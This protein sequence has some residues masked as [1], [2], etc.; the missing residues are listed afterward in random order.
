MADP[1]GFQNNLSIITSVLAI[2]IS[3]LTLGW[4]IYRDA[5][6]KPKLRVD[7]AVKKIIQKGRPVEGPY[8]FIEALNVGPIP[9]RIGL[10]FARKSW[11]KRRFLDPKRGTA[12]V[13]P[14]FGHWATTRA[15]KRLEVGDQANFVF[16]YNDDSFLKEDFMQVGVADGFGKIH[17]SSQRD[18][19]KVREKYRKDFPSK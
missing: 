13:Y 6:R 9:N 18:F 15:S 3:S 10:T 5:I 1:V 4:T 19:Q 7:V 2:M 17:W 12:M 16:P 14:D 8:L 11:I